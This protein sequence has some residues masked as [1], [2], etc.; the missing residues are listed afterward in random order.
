MENLTIKQKLELKKL[1]DQ[2]VSRVEISYSGG[3]DDGCI[4]HY[5]AYT[6]DVYG[7]EKYNRDIKL[8]SFSDAFD[9]YIYELLSDT[10]EWDWVNNEGGYGELVIDIEGQNIE[11]NHNQ[12]HIEQ[13]HYDDSKK[14]LEIFSKAIKDGSPITT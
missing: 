3:G 10:V 5:Q 7:K 11:I 14:S 9:D 13:Y 6:V 1:K 2:N 12:R 8:S 4:D